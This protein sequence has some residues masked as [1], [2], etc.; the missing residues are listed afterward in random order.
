[1][2]RCSLGYE[3]EITAHFNPGETNY[4]LPV[5]MDPDGVYDGD[6]TIQLGLHPGDHVQLGDPADALVII[7]NDDPAPVIGFSQSTQYVGVTS[8][9]VTVNV[10]LT[11]ATALPATVNYQTTDGTARSDG[12]ADYTT[13]SGTLTFA[14]G[15]TTASFPIY[16]SDTDVADRP[17]N[18][19]VTLLGATNASISNI[20][21]D[22]IIIVDDGTSPFD[23]WGDPPPAADPLDGATFPV[24]S[25]SG[26]GFGDG[27]FGGPDD[28]LNPGKGGAGSGGF[29][30]NAPNLGSGGGFGGPADSGGGDTTILDGGWGPLA[31]PF[32]NPCFSVGPTPGGIS[33][34][35]PG[36]RHSGSG[37]C[38]CG[39]PAVANHSRNS[40]LANSGEAVAVQPLDFRQSVATGLDAWDSNNL[41]SALVYRSQ[42]FGFRPTFQLFFDTTQ[43]PVQPYNISI[44]LIWGDQ[45]QGHGGSPPGVAIPPALHQYSAS[46]PGPVTQSGAYNWTLIVTVSFH[47]WGQVSRTFKGRMFVAV[48]NSGLGGGWGL[49]GQD[50]LFVYPSDAYIQYGSGG[51]RQIS[52]GSDWSVQQNDFGTLTTNSNGTYTCTKKNQLKEIFDHA[53]YLTAVVDPHGLTRTFNYDANHL[54]QSVVEPDGGVGQFTYDSGGQLARIDM[55]AGHYVLAQVDDTTHLLNTLVENDA[56]G[57]NLGIRSFTYTNQMMTTDTAASLV[58]TSSSVTTSFGY[59][60][61]YLSTVM[62]GG[63]TTTISA[64]T[65]LDKTN[66][67]TYAT[68]TDAL[69][70]P[71]TY[72]FDTSGRMLQMTSPDTAVRTWQRNSHGQVTQYLDPL[73]R[74]TA[75]QYDDVGDVTQI[76][77]PDT[78]VRK[79]EYDGTFH[80]L[81]KYTD[82]RGNVTS[83]NYDQTTGDLQYMTDALLKTTTLVWAANGLLQSVTDPNGHQVQYLNYDSARR[84]GEVLDG[85]GDPTTLQYDSAG[86]LNYVADAR[87][88]RIFTF[89][90]GRRRPM[91]IDNPIEIGG[92]QLFTYDQLGNLA[93]YTDANGHQTA[94]S[95]EAHGWLSSETDAVGTAEQR[96]TTFGDDALG[97]MTL[98]T[99]ANNHA[100]NYG[101][102]PL[103]RLTSRTVSL[104]PAGAEVYEYNLA[105]ELISV[106]DP[107]NNLTHIYHNS[108]GW[109]TAITDPLIEEVALAYDA[110]GNLTSTTDQRSNTTFF[111]YDP[112]NRVTK[113]HD[114]LTNDSTIAYD[115]AGNI[116]QTV[117][118]RGTPTTFAYDPA[119][120]VTLATNILGGTTKFF[121]DSMDNVTDVRDANQHDTQ[122]WYDALDRVTK[123]TD[124]AN[125]VTAVAYD[126]AGNVTSR[127]DADSHSTGYVYDALDRLT[128][129]SD[130]N[131]G[132]TKY[133]YDAVDNVTQVTDPNTIVTTYVYDSSNRLSYSQDY[134]GHRRT[135]SYDAAGNVTA[136][137][138]PLNHQTQYFYDQL[139]RLTQ[140]TDAASGGW[141]VTYDPAG[142][143]T[144][145]TDANSHTTQYNY[146]PLNRL[147][148]VTNALQGTI[149]YAYD[150]NGNTTG[151]KDPR[152]H[153]TYNSFDLLD[154]LTATTDTLAGQNPYVTTYSYDPAG[155]VTAVLDPLQ[156]RTQYGYDAVDRLTS[157]KTPLS[158]ET[159]YFYDPVGNTTKVQ[160][161]R[162]AAYSTSYYYD[163]RDRLTKTVDALNGNWTTVYDGNDNVLSRTDANN[164]TTSFGYDAINDVTSVLDANNHATSYAYD[165]DGNLTSVSDSIRSIAVYGYDQLDRQTSVTYPD[166]GVT[167]TG[168]DPAGNVTV[169]ADQLNHSTNYYYDPLNRVTK[170]TDALS[171]PTLTAYDANGNLTQVTDPKQNNTC[172][173]YDELNRRTLVTD[174]AT[175]TK[176]WTYDADSRLLS[177]TD[178]RGWHRN[179]GYDND[180]RLTAQT[181][182]QGGANPTATN[183]FSYNYDA[184]DNLVSASNTTG[185][186]TNSYTLAYDALDRLTSVA[187]PFSASLTYAYDAVGNRTSVADSFGGVISS[188]YDP[189]DSLKTREFGQTGSSTQ[190]RI[191]LTYDARNR[192]NSINRYTTFTP[193]ASTPS[194]RT[195]FGYDGVNRVTSIIHA[196]ISATGASTTF[197]NYSYSWDVAGR[198]TSKVENTKQST[199]TYDADNQVTNSTIPSAPDSPKPGPVTTVYSYDAAGNRTMVGYVTTTDNELSSD[200]KWDY[201]YDLE[202]NLTRKIKVGGTETWYFT[203]DNANHMTGARQESADYGPNGTA[204]M[205]AVYKY[206]VF[207]NRIEKDVTFSGYPT[208]ITKFVY[209]FTS[210][211][212]P[213][214][215]MLDDGGATTEV[216]ADLNSNNTLRSRYIRGDGVDQLFARIT[217]GTAYWYITD[218]EGS[219]RDLVY[220]NGSVYDHFDYDAFGNVVY[221]SFFAINDSTAGERYGYA[222]REFDA[223][224]GFIYERARYYNPADG[225]FLN[226]DPLAFDAGD[227]NLYRYVGN[228]PTLA[229]DPTGLMEVS[230]DSGLRAAPST[231][232]GPDSAAQVPPERFNRPSTTQCHQRPEPVP[233]EEES[234][235]FEEWW[236]EGRENAPPWMRDPQFGDP[237]GPPPRGTPWYGWLLHGVIGGA[238]L[239]GCGMAAG[240]K[241]PGAK[242]PKVSLRARVSSVI[243]GTVKGAIEP[244]GEAGS[245]GQGNFKSGSFSIRD[246]TGYPSRIAKPKGP[247][248]LLEGAEYDAARKAANEANAALRRADPAKYAGKQI[249]EIQP[250]KFGGSPTDP[251]NKIGL[252]PRQHAKYT[253][254]WN[255]LQRIL[256]GD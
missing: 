112:L 251:A 113:T 172:F 39:A 80:H 150:A 121:Y 30:N 246:W 111:Y 94:Y 211:S 188:V 17:A 52:G 87:F 100:W 29:N 226:Q 196:N 1:L 36:H 59:V 225:R 238:Q 75:M 64:T 78:A 185:G 222:G 136:S 53:G 203:Y 26:D 184:N 106:T 156:L 237:Y 170:T 108:R 137:Y 107:L 152:G 204:L 154:R 256:E 149:G 138:D 164:H 86:N 250:V 216:W 40:V 57:H 145:R 202:G 249:H 176:R 32:F 117:D 146:D 124:A 122:Y 15:Q 118:R 139:N 200:G 234:N 236:E 228:S 60:N 181:W 50:R 207:G 155:N 171:N 13:A 147:T 193:T 123:V 119:D 141:S 82:A 58:N 54:L 99:D 206:D 23:A 232:G 47:G 126:L 12:N 125:G 83:F 93:A 162:G 38:G 209:D 192:P 11:G 42:Q 76:T 14:A 44:A 16:I 252:T 231:S 241:V 253:T 22:D 157:V 62:R 7:H 5:A 4:I 198:L 244:L 77:F 163:P 97:R 37:D 73:S 49:A 247:F 142:N 34:L 92:Y 242:I 69:S 213:D 224:T 79:Y 248:G 166:G 120:R 148:L 31:Q 134:L 169:D 66:A 27:G 56:A 151:I 51:Y 129:I 21:E 153:W 191:D 233:W 110:E 240:P 227:V 28:P 95:Y 132:V 24:G 173:Q 178:R 96:T 35:P 235:R 190:L 131:S 46:T 84:V 245:A 143:V 67:K 128:Q 168:Y 68:V 219:V 105:G 167:H 10:N 33:A 114:A 160:T 158:R 180:G 18:F 6:K 201:T 43:A 175:N 186:V 41:Q 20:I 81:T 71:W 9:Y 144:S 63:S 103:G 85:A 116:T 101:Y 179:F 65:S 239:P 182:D 229:T 8:G 2:F 177:I 214:P 48:A 70:Q 102:D 127:T 130:P 221:D 3:P 194:V 89:F 140:T 90:D 88:H 195:T 189:V 183:V 218:Y 115:P 243:K 25:D 104:T 208:Q 210:S 174:P 45:P 199:Y 165:G 61:Q 197:E 254:F 55:P 217:S 159:D 135:L 109:V 205:V 215:S 161:P 91:E 187:E 220:T 212:S 223:E 74:P 230:G 98:V 133:Q 72:N 19:H 255:R